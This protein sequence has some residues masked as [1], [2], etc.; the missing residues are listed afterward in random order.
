MSTID[1][2]GNMISSCSDLRHLRY[3]INLRNLCMSTNGSNPVCFN[4]NY[5]EAIIKYCPQINILDLIMIDDI[6]KKCE[7]NRKSPKRNNT[8]L[9]NK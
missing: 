3:I 1:L 2:S 6:Y 5:Y 4:E 7:L 9:D 8:I